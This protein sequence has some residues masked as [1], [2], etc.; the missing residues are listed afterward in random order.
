MISRAFTQASR[1]ASRVVRSGSVKSVVKRHSH[2]HAGTPPPPFVQRKLP[3]KSLSE[4]AE[5]IWEDGVAP[6]TAIDFDVQTISTGRAF[7]WALS[8]FSFFFFL[9]QGV[10]M[11]DPSHLKRTVPRENPKDLQ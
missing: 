6:E 11:Y 1:N 9:Y 10:K 7:L 2:G 5:L 3:S 4:H 8:G